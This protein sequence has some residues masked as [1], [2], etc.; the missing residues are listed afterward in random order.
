MTN[1]TNPLCVVIPGPLFEEAKQQIL[2]TQSD[3]GL[4]EFRID[5]FSFSDINLIK[6]LQQLAGH[7]VIFTLRSIAQGGAYE[8]NEEDYFQRIRQLISLEPDYLDLEANFSAE[9]FEE[10][11]QTSSKTKIICSWHDFKET[12]RNLQYIYDTMQK[13]PAQLYKLATMAN[14]SLD[15]L[16]MLSFIKENADQGNSF[17]GI[18]MGE[19]G[20]LTRIL[21]SIFGNTITYVAS[22]AN[23]ATAPGQLDLATLISVYNFKKLN[24]NTK[25]FGLIGDPVR[26]SRS[27]LVHN[28]TMK[29]LELN[30]VYVK[31][32]VIQEELAEFF[33]LAKNIGFK[34]LSVTMPLKEKILDFVKFQQ[35]EVQSIGAANTLLFSLNDI[36][37]FNTDGIA[38]SELIE[39]KMHIKNKKIVILG[40]GGAAKAIAYALHQHGAKLIFLNRTLAKAKELATIYGGKSDTLDAFP[41]ISK[42]GYDV[43]INCTSIGMGKDKNCPISPEWLLTNRLVVD[44]VSL[45]KETILLQEAKKRECDIIYGYE[46]FILQAVKQFKIWFGDQIEQSAKKMIAKFFIC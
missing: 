2:N 20:Q 8:G 16:R 6:Q 45:P 32:R 17:I 25:V 42:E 12:P 4:Y 23:H 10:M 41:E 24:K 26:H 14:S 43:L 22:D 30:A 31:M 33:V 29:E 7:P 21:G 11:A 34:G 18:C 37:G 15:A 46:M 44:I 5:K 35:P 39:N 1:S 13:K 38:V 28:A 19:H 27:F 36:S 3:A 9:F 40:A